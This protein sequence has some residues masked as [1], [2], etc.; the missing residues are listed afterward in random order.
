M[1]INFIVEDSGPLQ[2]LGCATAAKNLYR[3]LSKSVEISYNGPSLD[4]DIC[5]LHTFGPKSLLY[6]KRFKKKKIITAH[7]TPH[8]NQGNLAFPHLVNWLY[9]PIYN[10]FDHIISVSKK[11]ERELKE[12]GCKPSVSTIYNGIDLRKFKVD[13]IKRKRFRKNYHIKDNS[14]CILTVAQRTPRKGVYDFL[15]LAKNFP[16][17]TF[18]W[19]GGFPYGLFSKD[20]RKVTKAIQQ[21]PKNALFPGFVEDIFEVYSGADAFLMPS[22]AEGHSIVMLEALSMELPMIAH[23]T[24]EFI[25]AFSDMIY[26]YDDIKDITKDV[27]VKEHLSEYKTRSKDVKKYDI[28]ETARQHVKLYEKIDHS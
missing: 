21:R 23:R 6:L 27:F 18:L 24:E 8:L 25:E 19:V 2:Y 4:F 22:Y 15:H 17:H 12:I 14:L 1:K 26:Y 10:Q 20:F 28:R 9:V 16:E 5:H 11:C 7:S 13:T 3:E